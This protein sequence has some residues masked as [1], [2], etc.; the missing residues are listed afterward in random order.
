L[1]PV[2]TKM[3]LAML[4][5]EPQA[6][7][8][9]MV[10]FESLG[11]RNRDAIVTHLKALAVPVNGI[12]DFWQLRTQAGLISPARVLPDSPSIPSRPQLTP[13]PVNPIT[14]PTMQSKHAPQPDRPLT[15]GTIDKST[16]AAV[17]P[18]L[19]PSAKQD[20]PSR[21]GQPK[22]HPQDQNA[23]GHRTKERSGENPIQ[24]LKSMN[25]AGAETMDEIE[26][27]EVVDRQKTNEA[28]SA[29]D[30][31]SEKNH[32]SDPA[33]KRMTPIDSSEWESK[34]L[35]YMGD[36]ESSKKHGSIG[37]RGEE[38]PVNNY[39]A[40]SSST[41]KPPHRI[42]ASKDMTGRY[43]FNILDDGLPGFPDV[44]PSFQIHGA[45]ARVLA[46]YPPDQQMPPV[47][48][49]VPLLKKSP[50]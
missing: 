21:L 32:A 1:D 3:I 47:R 31:G 5:A 49:F 27:L 34:R 28:T 39:Q 50:T 40:S 46:R 41:K 11:I 30:M 29:R 7:N 4:A 26:V 36:G 13:K 19:H 16:Y 2:L 18:L 44:D 8:V 20:S 33:K 9:L 35:A 25:G 15:N 10:A 48:T 6:T 12:E 23:V 22:A 45:P 43:H 38:T 17:N 37:R 42:Q 14:I 24:S